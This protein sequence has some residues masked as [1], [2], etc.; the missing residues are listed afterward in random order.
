MPYPLCSEHDKTL[1]LAHNDWMPWR[2]CPGCIHSC[3]GSLLIPEDSAR[4]VSFLGA[5]PRPQCRLSFLALEL[6]IPCT[7]LCCC[8]CVLIIYE[9]LGDRD[10][11]FIFV[12]AVLRTEP[13]II[14][15]AAWGATG[16]SEGLGHW[17][18]R[19]E[20]GKV[21]GRLAPHLPFPLYS[22]ACCRNHVKILKY[23]TFY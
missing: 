15:W 5:L 3:M 18:P 4:I 17:M 6:P 11:A 14:T 16:H 23:F 1:V 2:P 22:A 19:N 20:A 13:G 10:C 12:F 9:L 7:N 8:T 21:G